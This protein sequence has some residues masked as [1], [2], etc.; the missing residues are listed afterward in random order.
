MFSICALLI[1]AEDVKQLTFDQTVSQYYR[2]V[3][4]LNGHQA[5]WQQQIQKDQQSVQD[6]L[7]VVVSNC[8][9]TL[10][11][12]ETFELTCKVGEVKK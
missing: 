2:A 6:T 7:K 8:K 10:E 9:G 5:Q 11:G 12:L 1:A 3:A 4:I